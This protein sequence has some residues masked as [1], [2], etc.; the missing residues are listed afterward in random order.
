MNLRLPLL[1]AAAGAA[2]LATPV[3][4]AAPTAAPAP[5]AGAKAAPPEAS[6]AEGALPGVDLEGLSDEQR[7]VVLDWAKEAFCYCGCPHTLV[8][9]LKEH[10]T[11]KHAPRMAGLAVRLVKAGVKAKPELVK[12]IEGY[13]ASFDKRARLDVSQFGPPLGSPAAPISIVELSDFKCPYCRIVRPTLEEFVS[14]HSDRVKLFYKPFPIESHPGALEAS[15][16]GEWAREQGL[17]W[18]M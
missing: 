12:I 11:C 3:P 13:Y 7:R 2:V 16:A 14:S 8:Q 10:R 1:L 9:C 17:F 18:Q 4:A 6:A 5:P 15:Q